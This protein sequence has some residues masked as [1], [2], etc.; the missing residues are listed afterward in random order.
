MLQG[1]CEA[2]TVRSSGGPDLQKL[3]PGFKCSR[4]PLADGLTLKAVRGLAEVP[5]TRE[6]LCAFSSQV[7]VKTGTHTPSS[8]PSGDPA[9]DH[10]V[11]RA[12]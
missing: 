7:D 12:F 6:Q 3:A 5:K 11:G 10:K 1:L 2:A 9:S 4:P 8:Y